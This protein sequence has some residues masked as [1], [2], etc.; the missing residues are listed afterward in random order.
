MNDEFYDDAEYERAAQA[1]RERR[2]K[3]R[4]QAMIRRTI[5][6]IVLAIVFIGAAVFAGSLILKKQ[7]GTTSSP[8]QKP[9]SVLQTEKETA[10]PAQTEAQ[11]VQTEAQ[12]EKQTVTASNEEDL[13]AQAQLLAAGYDYDGAIALLRSIPDYESDSTL[14]AAIQEYET[15]K[16]SCVAVD[17]TTIPHI[18][19]HSLVNDPSAAFNAS[20]LGQAQADGMNAWMTTVDEFDKITQQLYDNGYVY[21]SLHDLVTET[22][23][24]DGTVHFTPNQSLMLPPG[25]KAIVLSVD[26]LSYYHSY[27][28]ASFPDKLVI[29]ENGDVKCHYVKTDGSENIGDFDVVPRLNTFLKEHPDGAYKGARGTMP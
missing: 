13:L 18:F 29:D 28:P 3:R 25:K 6:L 19:Y 23:D 17:V 9:S 15:T 27:E 5:S 11:P 2:R 16:S 1:R 21:V 24:A 10:A 12:S 22:T 20:T 4:R 7:N 26:D 8:A 14:T